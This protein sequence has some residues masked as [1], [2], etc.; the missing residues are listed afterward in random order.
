[1]SISDK[2]S[3]FC[4]NLRMSNNTVSNVRTRY[5]SI[6]K[7]LNKDFRNIDNDY[8]NSLY[9]GSYGRGTAIHVSDIDMLY[10]L[11]WEYYSKYNSYVSNV[12]SALLQAV[13]ESI[14][15]T[16]PVTYMSGDG[17][18][19]KVWFSDG[20]EFEVVPCF[21]Y[22]DGSGFCYPDTHDGGS[23]KTTN[24][25][26]E[27][28][29]INTWNNITNKNLRRLCR[30]IRAWKDNCN[31]SMGGLLIDTFAYR[32]LKDWEHYDKSY[33]YY[34]WM[35]RDFFK[36][37]SEQNDEQSYWIAVGSGQ[38]IYPKGK[39]TAKA[40]TAYNNALIA[41]EKEDKGYSYT[42]NDYWRA[43]YGTNF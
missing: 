12:Q 17:Q 23:W 1:M 27:I 32:F 35:T 25:K 14:Q 22:S 26:P 34:D 6:T 41:I 9:V 29:T 16:Y 10:I 7:R 30:M 42:A 38:F 36:Y 39:F 24:P 37:L 43:I 28:N 21:E 18:V 15:Q 13:K 31:V 11:P 33:F 3:A 40:K 19:V 2:F 4:S 8:L 20:V 5:H